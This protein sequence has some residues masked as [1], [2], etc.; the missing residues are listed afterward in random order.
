[1]KK[2]SYTDI[3][4]IGFALFSMF[5]GA[6]N[7][8]FPPFLGMSAG[9][10]WVVGLVCYYIADIGLALLAMLSMFK[11]GGVHSILSPA[12]RLPST[13]LMCSTVLC[14]GPMLAI[15]RTA[16]MTFETSIEPLFPS[17]KGVV[18][19]IVFFLLVFLCSVKESA[20]VDIVGK[21][22]TPLLLI[23]LLVLIFKGA[24]APLGEI[25]Q[26]PHAENVAG[27]GIKAG[28]QT[29]DVL[30]TLVF[31]GLILKSAH[32]KGYTDEK[33]KSS[34]AIKAGLVAGLILLIIYTGLTHLGA[35]VSSKYDLSIGRSSLMLAIVE[36]LMG[37][38][39]TVLYALVVA[40]ACITT[41][42]G[43]VS[44][45]SEYFANLL[46]GRLSYKSLVLLIC[47]FSA[48]VSNVGLDMLIS[49]AAPV[50][51]VVYPPILVLIALSFLP[52]QKRG[53]YF[54][55][56][57]C[58]VIMSSITAISVYGN[59]PMPFLKLLPFDHL[60]F[61]WLIPSAIAAIAGYFLSFKQEKAAF[62]KF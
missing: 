4:V 53:V 52:N 56:T 49:I 62:D 27:D 15:P 14:I 1:M 16:A 33:E 43:L 47:L 35:T 7:V 51:D 24:A 45:C 19:S 55:A 44:S 20:V 58:A 21:I 10:D 25:N 2:H 37:Q 32:E 12:G 11:K 38:R 28:Y 26:I 17:V 9:K 30:A 29:M 42:I 13:I 48:I 36:G 50:L 54:A 40:L 59:I 23:G 5:F 31:G 18:F 8:V 41:A 57:L 34:I 46:K 60:G 6:G 39:G 61:N 22:M 3:F